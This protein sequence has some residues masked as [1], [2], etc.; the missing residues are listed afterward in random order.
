MSGHVTCERPGESFY[1]F[2]SQA[3]LFWNSLSQV[4]KE[5]LVNTFIYHLQY[6]KSKSIR[7]KNVNMW[8]HVD[9]EMA[10]IIADNIGVDRPK[11]SEVNVTASSPAISQMNTPFTAYTQRV[12]VLVGNDFPEREVMATIQTLKE[13]GV[14]VHIVSDKIGYVKGNSGGKLKVDDTF[15]TKFPV[16]YD[17]LYVVGGKVN[18]QAAFNEQMTQWVNS[19]YQHYKPIGVATTGKKYIHATDKNNL[20]GVVFASRSTNFPDSFVQAVAKQRFWQRT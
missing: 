15:L 16:L 3:R 8:A 19:A 4:E 5:D 13:R 7:E 20:A 1:D 9:H 10:C 11:Q 18:R 12:A 17:S 6:V 2:F 14:F